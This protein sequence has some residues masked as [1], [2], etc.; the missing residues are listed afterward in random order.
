MRKNESGLSIFSLLDRAAKIPSTIHY[1]YVYK[2]EDIFIDY[3]K[4]LY[5]DGRVLPHYSRCIIRFFFY[6]GGGGS[7]FHG[8]NYNYIP[9]IQIDWILWNS[10]GTSKVL[11]E[12]RKTS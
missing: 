2:F 10:N 12:H 8:H 6:A 1:I 5:V 11:N 4:K 7:M 9:N 3:R